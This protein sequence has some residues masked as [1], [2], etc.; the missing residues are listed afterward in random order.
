MAKPTV[1]EMARAGRPGSTIALY[2]WDYDAGMDLVRRFWDAATAID[3]MAAALDEAARFPG[4]APAPLEA[5][6]AAAGLSGV[7]SCAIDV[8]TPGRS[9]QMQR[10][11]RRLLLAQER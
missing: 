11:G 8:P 9:I 2:V 5:P 7:E 3:P 1:A 4:C 10:R 6:F